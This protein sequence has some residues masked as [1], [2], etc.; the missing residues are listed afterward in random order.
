MR[1]K[2]TEPR[3]VTSKLVLLFAP[4]AASLLFCALGVLY[5][6]VVRHA[7]E[8]DTAVLAEKIF[9]VRADI[10]HAG[11]PA[12]LREELKPSSADERAGYWIRVTDASGGTV[13]ETP[14][15]RMP[16][17]IFPSA[18]ASGL[19]SKDY[20]LRGKLYSLGVALAQVGDQQFTIQVAQ[21]RSMDERFAKKLATLLAIV[22]VL[23]VIAAAAIAITVAKSGLHPLAQMTASLQRIGP[24]RLDARMSVGGWPRELQPLASAFDELLDRLQ[25]SFTRLSQFS[26]DLAHELRTPI[27]NIRGESEVA[28]TRPRSPE[29]YREVLES[30][31]AECQRLS[32]I[33]DNLLFIARAEAAEGQ[34]QPTSFAGRAAIEKIAADY[35][36]GADERQIAIV[37][38][39]EGNVYADPVLFRRA[40]GNLADNALRFTPDGGTIQFAVTQTKAA[41]EISVTDTGCGIEPKHLPRIFDRFYRAD[42]SRSSRGTGLGLAL[43]KSI[44]DLH[45]G[46]ATVESKVGRGTTITLSFPAP[47][48]AEPANPARTNRNLLD[49]TLQFRN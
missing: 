2:S 36:A 3:S 42:S 21:D 44:A 39:G 26:A 34:L 9:A 30:N 10:G 29:E 38:A 12:I 32:G 31:V 25:D 40:L 35:R 6:I 45:A 15:M 1:S 7:T 17:A 18:S 8:E 11:G 22:L 48:G 16:A 49:S 27:A 46:S 28:L 37:C 33:I 5:W 14:G 43:V 13:A 19:I 20:R 47:R 23:G 24:D 41:A 4:A